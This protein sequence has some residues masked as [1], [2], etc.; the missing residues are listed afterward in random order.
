MTVWVLIIA[1]GHVIRLKTKKKAGVVSGLL[2]YSVQV[3]TL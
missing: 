2:L 1:A 3:V